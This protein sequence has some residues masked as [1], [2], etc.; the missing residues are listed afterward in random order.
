[1]ADGPTVINEPLCPRLMITAGAQTGKEIVLSQELSIGRAEDNILRLFDPQVSRHHARVGREGTAYVLMDL[2]SA[3]GTLVDGQRLT[4]PHTLVPGER[5]TIC[6]TELLFL[7]AGQ[8][9]EKSVTVPLKAHRRAEQQATWTAS[10][11]S[12]PAAPGPVSRDSR[13]ALT[14]ALMLVG[15]VVVMAAIVAGI[16]ILI[17]DLPQK[18][19]L[20]GPATASATPAVASP[21]G[22]AEE[23][24]PIPAATVPA[25]ATGLE[26]T[27]ASSIDARVMNERLSEAQALVSRSKF[28]DATVIYESLVEEAPGDARPYVGWAW[29][30]I[31]DDRPQEA[32][33]QAQRAEDLD[34][35][36]ADVATVLARSYLETGDV[37]A[38]LPVAERA[39]SI[40]S[41]SAEAHAVLA[42]VQLANGQ[43]QAAMDEADLA[44]V[45]DINCAD[46]HRVRGWIYELVDGD[47]GRAV[48]ELQIAAGLQPELWLR[49]H[50][51]GLVLMDVE[52]YSTAI[53]AFQDALGI[54][55][56][57]VTYTAIGEAY[58]RLAQ[59]D[60]A[61]ASLEQALSLDA[62]DVDTYALLAA[63]Y[64]RLGRC[65]EA[66]RY[67]DQALGLDPIQ[68]M[69]L[70]ARDL[71]ESGSP[72]P[73]PSA[74]ATSAGPVVPAATTAA[75]AA[76]AAA[77]SKPVSSPAAV[78]GRFAFPV[79]NAEAHM[80]DTYVAK[81]DGSGQHLVVSGMH[82]P[83]FSPNGEWLAVNG[84][85]SDH[86]NMFIVKPDG[87]G[88]KKITDFI[89]DSLPS[90]SPDS[91]GFVLATTRESPKHPQRIYVV[92]QVPF[93]GGPEPGRV[94]AAP[95]GPVQGDYPTWTSDNHVVYHGCDYTVEP[96]TCGLFV[97]RVAGGPWKQLTNNAEDT[98]PAE[99]SG[100]I[101]FMSRRDGNWEVYVV[102]QDG[103]G[104]KR[105]TNS[106][107]NDGLPS[108]SRD[109]KTLAFASD[110]SGAW[111]IWA[112]S[113]DGSDQRKMFDLGG[114]GL[115]FD[116]Q[117]ER[118]SWAQ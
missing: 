78:S 27:P 14:I 38:A 77:T 79:W 104:L 43:S 20:S 31:Y 62:K 105:L 90:W 66:A 68:P 117:H 54:R 71:C 98:A 23:E 73:H 94:L 61:L 95:S 58:Y 67:I 53:I 48:G 46:A 101:A 91:S 19:G 116:W 47:M 50:E 96:Q 85:R 65:E 86:M 44:L 2:G 26:R 32:L 40:E 80:Y 17:P 57:A 37:A 99:S 18:I 13:R 63:S 15:A 115:A 25:A 51:L 114:G 9:I 103:S 89:E 84:E 106:A 93:T 56:K 10:I 72:T 55:P 82:Q 60:Q 34:P 112:M 88:L 97:I 33:D 3:N 74:T 81:A 8:E 30:L 29:A 45:Q 36:S 39:V 107:A 113:P 100:R 6:D 52:N 1:M 87:S 7:E 28:E 59:Y 35:G 5:I 24:L 83:A 22:Q 41:G 4:A 42:E 111:A 76:T 118:I 21:A 110:R 92:D 109:G 16:V 12:P 69:A 64:A 108:W 102:N 49:R 11:S 75:P 70:E